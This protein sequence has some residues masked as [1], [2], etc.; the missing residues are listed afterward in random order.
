MEL[1]KEEKSEC[2]MKEETKL[3]AKKKRRRQTGRVRGQKQ[4]D[5]EGKKRA[6]SNTRTVQ[7][8]V[9]T[10]HDGQRAHPPP[11]Q[12]TTERRSVEVIHQ[13]HALLLHENEV[14]ECSNNVRRNSHLHCGDRRQTP[15]TS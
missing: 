2:P 6:R 11:H 9:H 13:C 4:T 5:T 14:Y 15:K 8:L 10:L 1:K 3:T 7:S 12:Q